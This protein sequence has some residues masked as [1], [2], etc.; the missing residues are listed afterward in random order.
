MTQSNDRQRR[1]YVGTLEGVCALSSSDGG[2]NWEQGEMTPL[3]NAAARL[4]VS[5]AE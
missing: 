1:L 5:P 4:S 2:H 3:S